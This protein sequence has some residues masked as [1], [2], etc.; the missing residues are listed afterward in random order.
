MSQEGNRLPL[1]EST[2]EGK[3]ATEKGVELEGVLDV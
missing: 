1:E 2:L 3:H